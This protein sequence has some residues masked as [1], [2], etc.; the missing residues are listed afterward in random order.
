MNVEKELTIDSGSF[1]I[2]EADSVKKPHDDDMDMNDGLSSTAQDYEAES[3]EGI[4]IAAEET[5]WIKW[6]KYLVV[7][8][9]VLGTT[10]TAYGAYN[11]TSS[12]QQD[13]FTSQVC[14]LNLFLFCHW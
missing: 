11:F 4:E 8:V 13:D 7:L 1:S 12:K 10:L 5:R 2:S 9:L 6:S 14:N 3:E